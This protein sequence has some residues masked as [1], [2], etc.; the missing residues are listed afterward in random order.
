MRALE[1]C[2]WCILY[3]LLLATCCLPWSW[4]LPGGNVTG[5]RT[6]QISHISVLLS[7][8]LGRSSIMHCL[9]VAGVLKAEAVC[10]RQMPAATM[11][12]PAR[13]L[14][15]ECPAAS[16][17]ASSLFNHQQALEAVDPALRQFWA[18]LSVQERKKLCKINRQTLFQ[19]IRA[20]YC[21][22]CFGLFQ[23]RYEELRSS[24]TLDCPACH[25][26]YA[27]LLVAEDGCLTL[28]DEIIQHGAL[29]FTTFAEAELRERE[30]EMQ[31]MTGDI[32][33]SGWQ[34][35]P[36]QTVCRCAP[37][38]A[39]GYWPRHLALA[40]AARRH[41]H[42]LPGDMHASCQD[43]CTPGRPRCAGMSTLPCSHSH[44][45]A[46]LQPSNTLLSATQ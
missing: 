13:S 5:S 2:C 34:K 21:S 32:C 38:P 30:R 28:E 23:L 7:D 12:L 33:G 4:S 17:H 15:G 39:A 3:L 14:N 45:H 25:Q 40:A 42:Q 11:A 46:P 19:K 9:R 16:Y 36:G 1:W 20:Q 18:D 27:G 24:S 6:R 43:T 41:A 10:G 44:E 35:R 29:I 26:C 8:L 22:R 31:F 37:G